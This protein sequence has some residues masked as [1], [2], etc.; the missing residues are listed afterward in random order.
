[1][2][3]MIRI[4]LFLLIPAGLLGQ[5][6]GA[7]APTAKQKFKT[8]IAKNEDAAHI[9]GCIILTVVGSEII[10]HKT[11]NTAKSVLGGAAISLF[12]SIVGK[13]VVHD[14][15]LGLGVYSNIDIL[16]DGFGTAAGMITSRVLIDIKERNNPMLYDMFDEQI[17]YRKL[18]K[19][20]SFK[21]LHMLQN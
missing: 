14:K 9:D 15:L 7:P 11:H 3:S 4:L 19:K 16:R 20:W 5:A 18:P 17:V 1:M 21:R 8:F 10:Y 2:L 12:I 13:E 6:P